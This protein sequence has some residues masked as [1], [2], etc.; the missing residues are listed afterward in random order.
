MSMKTAV[1]FTLYLIKIL[2]P[3][4]LDKMFGSIP[5]TQVTQQIMDIDYIPLTAAEPGNT[6]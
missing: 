2:N 1:S 4:P 3:I 5:I 6:I